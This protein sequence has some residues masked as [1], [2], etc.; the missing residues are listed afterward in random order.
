MMEVLASI[1]RRRI[2]LSRTIL[3]WNSRLAAVGTASTSSARY[4][5]PPAG[6]ELAPAEQL[7]P[8]RDVVDDD[9]MLGEREHRPVEPAVAL[10]VEHAC[11][12]PA[13]RPGAPRPGRAA[14]PPAPPARPP[15]S[16]EPSGRR[17]D[18]RSRSCRAIRTSSQVGFFQFGLRSSAAGWYVTTSGMPLYVCTLPRSS[19]RLFRTPSIASPAVPAHREDHLRPQQLELAVEI[20]DA[21]RDLIGQRLSVLGR[22]ALDDVGDVHRIRGTSIASRIVSSSWPACPTNGRP[23]ASS[24]AP[25]PSP[26]STSLALRIALAGHRVGAAGAELAAVG[27]ADPLGHR[28]ERRER[29][30]V[31]PQQHRRRRQRPS[32]RARE[33]AGAPFFHLGSAPSH[34]ETAAHSVRRIVRW[35]WP[36]A[37]P[38]RADVR[39]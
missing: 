26:T 36:V 30:Q 10:P 5:S 3:A 13:P 19:P 25:G 35:A 34:S 29:A 28:I 16:R 37:A 20:G 18:Q 38:A 27:G 2:A 9:P 12:P 6:L 39:G 24:V 7:V 11:R 31:V 33:S 22:T 23:V 14:S 32:C 1:R 17:T 4:S 21:G 8:Q 15:G